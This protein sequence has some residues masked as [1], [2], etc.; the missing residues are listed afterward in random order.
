M[1]K[2]WTKTFNDED[3]GFSPQEDLSENWSSVCQFM[4]KK[5]YSLMK[6]IHQVRFKKLLIIILQ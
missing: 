3:P 6:E 1:S 2:A 4:F 5:F